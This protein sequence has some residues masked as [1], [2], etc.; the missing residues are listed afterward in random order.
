MSDIVIKE[1]LSKKDFDR[2]LKF[3]YKLF[4]DDK[5]WVPSLLLDERTTFNEK[6]NP[7]FEFCEKKIFLAYRDGE[8][9]GRVVAMLN[10]KSNEIWKQKRMRFGWLD[11]IDDQDV[12]AALLA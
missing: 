10:K 3:P 12:L 1:V 6:K 2:F 11:Y 7:A 8:I 4:K 5:M 9:V